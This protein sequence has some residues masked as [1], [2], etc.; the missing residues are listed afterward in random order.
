MILLVRKKVHFSKDP[1]EYFGANHKST[2]M[3]DSSSHKT[4]AVERDHIFVWTI[5]KII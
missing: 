1:K 2:K 4:L 5:E 3:T